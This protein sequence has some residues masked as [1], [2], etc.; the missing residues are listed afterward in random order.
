MLILPVE[1]RMLP[2]KVEVPVPTLNV[3][4]PDTSVLP[5]KVFA[6]VPV[7]KVYAPT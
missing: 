1:A 3:F 5:F 6:P 7:E 2:P 4:D